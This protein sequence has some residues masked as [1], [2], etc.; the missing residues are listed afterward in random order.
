[1]SSLSL[2]RKITFSRTIG[3]VVGREHE[4]E[5]VIRPKNFDENI[6]WQ[7]GII[8]KVSSFLLAKQGQK[9]RGY[10]VVQAPFSRRSPWNGKKRGGTLTSHW[11][12][13]SAA[14]LSL[15]RRRSACSLRFTFAPSPDPFD[16]PSPIR[17]TG[18]SPLTNFHPVHAR[19]SVTCKRRN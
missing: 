10:E 3:R 8:L 17:P 4:A 14:S 2:S 1:M 13:G 11:L 19:D 6:L 9:R 7:R 5:K 15:G 18:G 16:R 12:V